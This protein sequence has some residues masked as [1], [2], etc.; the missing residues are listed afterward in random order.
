MMQEREYADIW[1]IFENWSKEDKLH[2]GLN[3]NPNK[4]DDLDTLIHKLFNI[5]LETTI[6]HDMTDNFERNLDDKDVEW[7]FSEHAYALYKIKIAREQS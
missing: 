5:P 7:L 2:P 1:R 4:M 6:I 3:V